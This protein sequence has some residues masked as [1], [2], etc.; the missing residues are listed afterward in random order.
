MRILHSLL[1]NIQQI[2]ELILQETAS[3]IDELDSWN[4]L[5]SQIKHSPNIIQTSYQ[6]SSSESLKKAVDFQE[7]FNIEKTETNDYH[8]FY[9]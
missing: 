1:L 2:H 3:S 8:C 4:K 5:K 6:R 9:S 7:P